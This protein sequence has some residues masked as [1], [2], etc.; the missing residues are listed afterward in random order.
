MSREK[1]LFELDR[2]MELKLRL[3]A[4]KAANPGQTGGLA[5]DLEGLPERQVVSRLID[6]VRRL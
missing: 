5:L 6:R 1:R 2:R 3:A 4:K